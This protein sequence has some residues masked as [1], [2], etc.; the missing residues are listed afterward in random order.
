LSPS[1]IVFLIAALITATVTFLNVGRM[2]NQLKHG[3]PA[4]RRASIFLDLPWIIGEHN[5]LFPRSGL[6]L[7]FWLSVIFL[8]VWLACVAFSLAT[9]L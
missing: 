9:R 8:I 7:T 2:A 5:R 3:G 1:T 4:K 6:M